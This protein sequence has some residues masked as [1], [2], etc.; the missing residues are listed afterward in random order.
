MIG[1]WENFIKP[2]KGF[3]MVMQYLMKVSDEFRDSYVQI[4]KRIDEIVDKLSLI[5]VRMQELEL[6]L[7]PNRNA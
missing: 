7:N 6:R 3:T 5:E 1:L 4:D 2:K